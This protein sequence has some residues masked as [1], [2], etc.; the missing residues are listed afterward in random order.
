MKI[1]VNGDGEVVKMEE[2]SRSWMPAGGCPS[3]LRALRCDDTPYNVEC[4]ISGTQL[5]V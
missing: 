5:G 4:D 1:G 3:F 2:W